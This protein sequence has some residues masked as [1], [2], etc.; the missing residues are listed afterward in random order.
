MTDE[1]EIIGIERKWMVLNRI[2]LKVPVDK[3]KK[4]CEFV[5]KSLQGEVRTYIVEDFS[6]H[7]FY[8]VEVISTYTASSWGGKGVATIETKDL[9]LSELNKTT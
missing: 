7:G 8:I 9:D 4:L 3:F 2:T 6:K 5:K 1:I